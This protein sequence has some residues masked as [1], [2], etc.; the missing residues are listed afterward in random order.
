MGAETTISGTT[1]LTDEPQKD[2]AI[3]E[4]VYLLSSPVSPVWKASGT[5]WITL[6][7][8]WLNTV[9]QQ[10]GAYS[11]SWMLW[12]LCAMAQAEGT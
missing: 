3:S 2:K 12:F 1:V 11:V 7:N 8:K 4:P 5:W 10:L 9:V 6:G